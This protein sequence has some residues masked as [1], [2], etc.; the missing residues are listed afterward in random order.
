MSR[1]RRAMTAFFLFSPSFYFFI[2]VVIP[3]FRECMPVKFPFPPPFPQIL[4]VCVCVCVC[5]CGWLG[6]WMCNRVSVY[7]SE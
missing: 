2:N 7:V 3:N 5:V 1:V 4:C 6:G